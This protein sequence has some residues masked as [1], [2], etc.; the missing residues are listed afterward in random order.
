MGKFSKSKLNHGDQLPNDMYHIELALKAT[1]GDVWVGH[2]GIKTKKNEE[3]NGSHTFD[4]T[5]VIELLDSSS[6]FIAT[7]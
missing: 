7:S 2:F 5:L 3:G 1:W 4:K 6:H